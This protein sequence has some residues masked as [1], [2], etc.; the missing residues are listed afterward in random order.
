MLFAPSPNVGTMT[1]A[2]QHHDDVE[3]NSTRIPHRGQLPQI[4]VAAATY[5]PDEDVLPRNS[6][7]M[8]PMR[9]RLEPSS[10]PPPDIPLAQVSFSP[11]LPDDHSRSNRPKI[12]PITGEAVILDFLG[13]HSCSDVT[14]VA[15]S[16]GLPFDGDDDEHDDY[17]GG[18][19]DNSSSAGSPRVEAVSDYPCGR[20]VKGSSVPSAG[21]DL[22]HLA[23]GALQAY[24]AEPPPTQSSHL[25]P[26]ISLSTRQLT[27][28]D[29]R[30]PPP[31]IPASSFLGKEAPRCSLDR[32]PSGASP[33]AML[34]PASGELPPLQMD[35][36]RSEPNGQILPSLQAALGNIGQLST[37]P[38]SP[39]DNDASPRPVHHS[40]YPR[41]PPGPGV[42]RLHPLSHISPPISPSEAYQ[43]GLPS[44]RP[45]PAGSSYYYSP[46]SFSHR[47]S[48]DCGDSTV[49]DTPSTEQSV[50]TPATSTATSTSVADRMS[51]DGITNPSIGA[52]YTTHRGTYALADIDEKHLGACR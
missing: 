48:T 39:C 14:R 45:T 8:K 25:A 11:L 24:A 23:A 3:R 16:E 40:S 49:A 35:S 26:D 19:V 31:R 46:T 41:S 27:L 42:S 43:R 12:R 47:P 28:H 4:I 36:P 15:A 10:S 17:D 5:D 51:I 29:D 21:P 20:D 22:Q 37:G 38:R 44:P 30:P 52:Y 7:L 33:V 2:T 9:P 32:R 18:C 34:T 50:P 1:T 13:N 6:P